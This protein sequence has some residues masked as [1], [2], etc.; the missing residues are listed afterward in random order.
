M[1]IRPAST[2]LRRLARPALL[3]TA[4]VIALFG[5]VSPA[6]AQTS[7]CTFS[8]GRSP[9][10]AGCA[11]FR[12][13]PRDGRRGDTFTVCDHIADH[14]SVAVYYRIAGSARIY[15]AVNF[16]GPRAFNGCFPV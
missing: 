5:S 7:T 11:S 10:N 3:L 4:V 12:P 9:V 1:T 16:F 6:S 8:D 15:H 14:R 2:P 13:D